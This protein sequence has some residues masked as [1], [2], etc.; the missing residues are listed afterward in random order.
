MA[1]PV[2]TVAATSSAETASFVTILELMLLIL[3]SGLL[4]LA[5]WLGT[6]GKFREWDKMDALQW[7]SILD[8]GRSE[9]VAKA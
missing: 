5:Y 7:M 9:K 4:L 2:T 6:V 3:P 8:C 1:R